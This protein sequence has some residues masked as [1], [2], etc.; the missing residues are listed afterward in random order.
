MPYLDRLHVQQLVLEYATERAGTLLP[1]A[2]KELGLGV[3]NPRT[4]TIES[5]DTIRAA[6]A[7]HQA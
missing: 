5:V 2:G 3:V 6:V 4:E 1:F 7:R